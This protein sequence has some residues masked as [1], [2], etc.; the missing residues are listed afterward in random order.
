MSATVDSVIAIPIIEGDVTYSSMSHVV[1]GS[2]DA[3]G[4]ISISIAKGGYEWVIAL[5]DTTQAAKID[6]VVGYIKLSDA[7]SGGLMKLNPSDVSGSS[8]DVGTVTKGATDEVGSDKTLETLASSFSASLGALRE[9]ARTDKLLKSIKN[10][11]ANV[12]PTGDTFY[13]VLPYFSLSYGTQSDVNGMSATYTNPAQVTYG[14]YGLYF[15]V[16]DSSVIRYSDLCGNPPGKNLTVTPP[17]TLHGA[18]QTGVDDGHTVTVLDNTHMDPSTT[19]GTRES[20]GA[21]YSAN[22][23]SAGLYAHHEATDAVDSEFGFNWGSAYGFFGSAPTGQWPMKIG[24]TEVARF[25]IAAG[26]PVDANGQVNVY[27]LSVKIV[28]DATTHAISKVQVKMYAYNPDSHSFDVI[29]D[30]TTMIANLGEQGKVGVTYYGGSAVE[31]YGAATHVG[32]GIFEFSDF[33]GKTYQ[34]EA[35]H[36]SGSNVTAS[37]IA[38]SYKLNGADVRLDL[39]PSAY[40]LQ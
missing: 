10:Y 25:E 15:D 18:T 31:V 9:V 17:A 16:K 40:T 24:G 21:P 32:G 19:S 7:S 3:S 29:T 4:N 28:A 39:R 38:V 20:C 33:Q 5:L 36:S 11:Y 8:L 30:P 6:Q 35:G 2:I 37:T 14:G 12:S 22:L 13:T 26:S 1:K 23:Y 34:W 27:I